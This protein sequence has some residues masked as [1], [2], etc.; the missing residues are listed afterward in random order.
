[1]SIRID[2]VVTRGG[3]SGQTSLGDGSRVA[4]N[5]ARIEAMGSLDELN[6]VVGLLRSH[7]TADSP[8]AAHLAQLQNWLF[9]MGALLCQPQKT[10]AQAASPLGETIVAEL[11]CWVEH[12]REAQAPLTSFILPGGTPAAAWAH[13]ARTQARTTERR[14]V[15]LA[16]EEA[17]SPDLLKI[18]NRVSDYFFVLARHFNQDGRTDLVWTPA[19]QRAER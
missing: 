7:G 3:D 4:K 6:A 5:S 13:L 16:Q 2:R 19:A 14:V 18:L 12:L 9:D 8:V 17:V 11:E 10:E 1:M 15:A